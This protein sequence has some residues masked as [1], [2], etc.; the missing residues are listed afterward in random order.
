MEEKKE[1]SEIPQLENISQSNIEND[2]LPF[3]YYH[4]QCDGKLIWL[5]NYD[6]DKNIISVFM[7]DF[8]DHKEKKIDKVESL[9]KARYIRQ[10]LIN[11]GWILNKK[12]EVQITYPNSDKPLNRKDKRKLQKKF[13]QALGLNPFTKK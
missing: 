8:G 2:D 10:E 1:N 9:E 3:S 11:N 13:N 5:C 7:Y 12:P 6:F 4:P